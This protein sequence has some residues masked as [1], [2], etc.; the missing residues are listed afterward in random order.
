[1]PRD[2]DDAWRIFINGRKQETLV[3]D[4][5]RWKDHV[6]LAWYTEGP[7]ENVKN[8]DKRNASKQVESYSNKALQYLREILKS[9]KVERY[10]NEALLRE[11]LSNLREGS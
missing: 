2:I 1:M 11:K 4:G 7:E 9:Q 5:V 10:S 6:G 3:A 8:N